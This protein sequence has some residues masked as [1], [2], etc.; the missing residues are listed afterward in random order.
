MERSYVRKTPIL[1]CIMTIFVKGG[2]KN[3]LV[4]RYNHNII[5]VF[6][7]DYLPYEFLARGYPKASSSIKP[8][9]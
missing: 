7:S 8:F 1:I 3:I 5:C 2:T 6:H 9:H 4:L